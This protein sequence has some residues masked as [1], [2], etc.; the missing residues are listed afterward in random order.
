M[1]KQNRSSLVALGGIC[2]AL[3]V[4]IML[5]TSI[6]P[7]ATY[8]AP[9]LAGLALL[10]MKEELGKKSALIS[11]TA[12]SFLSVFIV[13]EKES[14]MMFVFLFGYYPIIK[15]EFDKI[16]SRVIRFFAKIAVFN[17]ATFIGYFI[18]IKL[19]AMNYI[20]DEFGTMTILLAT[21]L[22]GNIAFVIYDKALVIM[23]AFYYYKVRKKLGLK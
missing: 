9:M 16:K 18:I 11:Y 19:F 20:M 22:M 13:P 17:I 15:E 7:L 1:R 6:I 5:S 8:I 4:V 3:S 10:P 12:V 23:K 14:A 2:A 21:I